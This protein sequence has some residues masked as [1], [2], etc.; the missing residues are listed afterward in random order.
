[1]W[2]DLEIF[3]LNKQLVQNFFIV[4]MLYD[5]EPFINIFVN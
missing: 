2:Q 4:N 3:I 5:I 1:M